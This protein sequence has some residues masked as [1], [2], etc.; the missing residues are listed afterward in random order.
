MASSSKSPLARRA[1]RRT[2]P[3]GAASAAPRGA[4]AALLALIALSPCMGVE[5][6]HRLLWGDISSAGWGHLSNNGHYFLIGRP[7][8][9]GPRRLML[10]GN[11]LPEEIGGLTELTP[12]GVDDAGNWMVVG[13]L[14]EYPG[15]ARVMY[16]GVI[17]NENWFDGP[18][19]SLMAHLNPQGKMMWTNGSTVRA[20]VMKQGVDY[21]D[22]WTDGWYDRS[23]DVT[24]EGRILWWGRGYG[25][26]QPELW[27]DGEAL[28]RRYDLGEW[29]VTPSEWGSMPW[30]AND[31]GE[32]AW[33]LRRLVDGRYYRYHV[34]KG[35][36]D[37]TA[38]VLGPNRDALDSFARINSSGR[39]LWG[40]GY[41]FWL[42][43]TPMFFDQSL[44]DNTAFPQRLN[45]RNDIVWYR[46]RFVGSQGSRSLFVNDY[47]LTAGIGLTQGTAWGVQVCDLNDRGDVLWTVADPTTLKWSLYLSSPVP[48]PGS[49]LLLLPSAALLLRRQRG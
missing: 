18:W 27:F 8:S 35:D 19:R 13:N 34:F 11:L 1:C 10:D 49:L 9:G 40:N 47:D 46:Q 43:E 5:Y 22:Q 31:S 2:R 15:Y 48:E 37:L 21:S 12:G 6:T 42:D 44:P 39:V 32:V 33:V 16:N 38:E 20:T 24:P 29:E 36:Y 4:L 23:W 28:A 26:A 17:Q 14:I 3:L 25:E 45:E 7:A 41:R 30:Q